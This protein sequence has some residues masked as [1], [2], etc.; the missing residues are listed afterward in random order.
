MKLDGPREFPQV[1]RSG[2]THSEPCWEMG[3]AHGRA[4]AQAGG[5]WGSGGH[6]RAA[7]E[8]LT[9]AG[10]PP[11]V[12]P[13]SRTSRGDP[14]PGKH[15]D[16]FW[17]VWW[18]WAGS[19]SLAMKTFYLLY[20]MRFVYPR[21]THCANQANYFHFTGAETIGR[22]QVDKA[23]KWSSQGYLTRKTRI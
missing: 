20:L 11:T 2:S 15:A 23:V 17:S 5:G 7:L 21:A 22:G 3:Q 1:P 6:I 18:A 10:S 14:G 19:A 16:I 9:E 8:C 12:V 13:S 4:R